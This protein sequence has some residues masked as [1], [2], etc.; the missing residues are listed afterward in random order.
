MGVLLLLICTPI[1]FSTLFTLV[2]DLV[3]K[4][5]LSRNIDED[6]YTAKFEEE[7]LLKKVAN[8]RQSKQHM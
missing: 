7:N 5:N 6:Y 1:G 2:G 4:P 3:I 8:C